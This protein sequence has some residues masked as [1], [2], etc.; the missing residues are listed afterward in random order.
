MAMLRN[1]PLGLARSEKCFPILK[2][3]S[4]FSRV[5][6]ISGPIDFSSLTTDKILP[7]IRP[8]PYNQFHHCSG[9]LPTHFSQLWEHEIAAIHRPYRINC[10]FVLRPPGR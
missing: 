2:G 10:H 6:W 3:S 5:Q 8:L 7:E 9:N 4:L 1:T